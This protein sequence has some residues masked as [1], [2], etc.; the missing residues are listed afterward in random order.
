MG[1]ILGAHV[2]YQGAS[3]V[4]VNDFC[5]SKKTWNKFDDKVKQIIIDAFEAEREQEWK[6]SIGAYYRDLE[7]MKIKLGMKVY[8]PTPE[9]VKAIHEVAVK[10]CWPAAEK[11]VG[12][13]IFKEINTFL[14]ND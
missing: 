1:E 9:Q 10:Y 8:K 14:G 11:V 7:T 2:Q 5:I 4:V 13:D 12:K 3:V 6:D